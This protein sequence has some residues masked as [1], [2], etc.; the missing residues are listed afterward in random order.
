M[1]NAPLHVVFAANNN[2]AV[3]LLVSAYSLM[4]SAEEGTCYQVHVLVPS[5]FDEAYQQALAAMAHD[6]G[7]PDPLFCNMG[8]AYANMQMRIGH[9]SLQTYYRLMIPELFDF[10][11]CLYLDVDVVVRHDVSELFGVLAEDELV[12]GVKA[13]G[14]YWPPESLEA[15]A[16]ELGVAA[17]D[18]YVNAGVLVLNVRRMREIGL[19]ERFAELVG[20]DFRS[21]D[22]DIINNACY[23]HIHILPPAYNAMTIYRIE[24]MATYDSG[25]RPYLNACHTRDEWAKACE[26]PVIVHYANQLKPWSTLGVSYARLWW[27]VLDKVDAYLPC[28]ARL[29]DQLFQEEETNAA[30]REGDLAQAKEQVRLLRLDRDKAWDGFNS[31]REAV[32]HFANAIAARCELTFT[33]ARKPTLVVDDISDPRA[34][35]MEPTWLGENECGFLVASSMGELEFSVTCNDA[36]RLR[37]I[38]RSADER[39]EAGNRINYWLSFSELCIDG[40]NVLTAPT[41]ACYDHSLTHELVVA[42]GTTLRMRIVWDVYS[43]EAKL[44]RERATTARLKASL[45]D[46]DRT[47]AQLEEQLAQQRNLV[48]ESQALVDSLTQEVDGLREEVQEAASSQPAMP[49][50]R[51][52]GRMRKS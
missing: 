16:Q 27:D 28:K 22:Q 20:R 37:I 11:T 31:L 52:W 26:D 43:L 1:S 32:D 6:L 47:I 24:S 36:G 2:Y 9:T 41:P 19:A 35:T 17:F 12:A 50:Q 49:L 18:Q 30:V 40:T 39:D 33:S 7:M 44:R 4:A 45:E 21:Q 51:L 15:K 10:D 8:S 23:G 13:A 29:V 34:Y 14:Y 25:E 3:P 5:D 42:P 46:K 38:L 48:S